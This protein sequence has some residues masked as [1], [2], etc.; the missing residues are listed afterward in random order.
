MHYLILFIAWSSEQ[1]TTTYA[2]WPVTYGMTP[3]PIDDMASGLI[4]L[5]VARGVTNPF[6]AASQLIL[7]PIWQHRYLTLASCV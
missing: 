1:G 3:T 2:T 5:L 7:P 4:S 6:H